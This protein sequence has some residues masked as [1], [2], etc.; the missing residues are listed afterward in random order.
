MKQQ[1]A[2]V[3]VPV[4]IITTISTM[5][6]FSQLH[7]NQLQERMAGNQQK[8][9]SARLAAEKGIFAA[10]E[11]IKTGA[12]SS[13]IATTLNGTPHTNP[14]GSTLQNIVWSET[15]S[16]FSFESIGKVNGATTYLKTTIKVSEDSDIFDDAVVGC[17]SVR[18][19]GSGN[20][21]AFSVDA[22][23]NRT[24]GQDANVS[25]I[26]GIDNIT[27]N[28]DDAIT[29]ATS[30]YSGECD[31]LNIADYTD[32]N[33]EEQQGEISKIKFQVQGE[34]GNYVSGAST[35]FDGVTAAGGASPQ[36][37][38]VL[39]EEKKVYVFD[40]LDVG[41]ETITIEGD[42]T[43]YVAGGFTTSGSTFK[44]SETIDSSLTILTAGKV[45]IGTESNIFA[46]NFVTTDENE[47]VRTPLTLYSS[48]DSV[49]NNNAAV[50]LQGN[51][52]VYMNLY[53]PLGEVNYQG[54][55][56]LFGAIRGKKVDVTGNG[57]VHYD[58]GLAD[59]GG[60]SGAKTS[61]SSVSYYYPEE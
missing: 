57:G 44:L 18:V 15:D 24:T 41:S 1:K 9:I 43:I 28:K 37:L 61:Y 51:G 5:L 56:G 52:Q 42:V 36:M 55:N 39:G 14:S 27:Y 34:P 19:W 11:A 7:D 60:G 25:A 29:G 54:N 46:D 49:G 23:G 40:Q 26:G 2:F 50:S 6:T 53:V 10:F 32:D 47:T 13:A 4:L 21:D 48:N 31:P 35:N 22:D 38:T 30:K 12:S 3:L 16:S 33:G 8:E 59:V 20:I 58:G 17:E 45:A